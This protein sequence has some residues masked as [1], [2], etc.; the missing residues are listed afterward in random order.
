M[1]DMESVEIL[2]GPQGTLF[3]RNASVG[4]LSLRTATPGDS[5]SISRV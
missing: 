3:G 1:L 4:A 2:R 5:M